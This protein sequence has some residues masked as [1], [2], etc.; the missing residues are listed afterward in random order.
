MCPSGQ[1]KLKFNLK[2]RK[3]FFSKLNGD[4]VQVPVLHHEAYMLPM[5]IDTALKAQ[6]PTP[7]LPS[8][9]VMR[10]ETLSLKH[11]IT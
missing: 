5:M 1:W 7:I 9:S 8:K 6:V 4:L 10:S 2:P 3:A 11:P